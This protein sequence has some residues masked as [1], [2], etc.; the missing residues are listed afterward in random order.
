[1]A[2]GVTLSEGLK[3]A[4][5]TEAAPTRV[6]LDLEIDFSNVPKRVTILWC[7]ASKSG[8]GVEFQG[9]IPSGFSIRVSVAKTL[10]PRDSSRCFGW[11]RKRLQLKSETSA[12]SK[13]HKAVVKIQ[14]RRLYR[15][16]V[17]FAK[18]SA[19]SAKFV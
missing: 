19:V 17:I 18:R 12:M 2:P 14:I 8:D 3:L 7:I 16:F 9:P 10:G 6:H 15:H 1:M 11:C 4:D 13:L 5:L